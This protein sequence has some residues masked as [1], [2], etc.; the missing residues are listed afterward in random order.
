MVEQYPDTVE[1]KNGATALEYKARIEF[2]T[3]SRVMNFNAQEV[4]VK[5]IVYM[6]LPVSDIANNWAVKVFDADQNVLYNGTVKQ[7]SRGQLNA[8]IW[9]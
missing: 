1:L 8:R 6:P 5:A 3:N 9:V 4:L 7:F 2:G